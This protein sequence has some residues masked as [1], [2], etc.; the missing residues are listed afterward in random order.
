[1]FR[2]KSTR[3]RGQ[4]G[5]RFHS[6][7]LPVICFSFF[8]KIDLFLALP[9]FCCCAG[10]S[11]LAVS[12][13]YSNCSGFSCCP[14]QALGLQQLRLPGSRVQAVVMVHRPSCPSVCGIFSDQGQ[15][16]CLLHWQAD[17]LPL[18]HWGSPSS[19]FSVVNKVSF[20][21]RRG[22]GRDVGRSQTKQGL[23]SHRKHLGI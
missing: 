15:H 6:G 4:P 13:G 7:S 8:R 12:G 22:K 18:S 11:L 16:P 17:S 20:N 1:M 9:S 3:N 14:A 2:R 19:H 10:F 5:Q 23:E 21:S